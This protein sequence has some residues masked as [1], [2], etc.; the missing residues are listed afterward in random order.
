MDI[1]WQDCE[2]LVAVA[3]TGSFSAA[4]RRLNL[5]QPTVSR[6]IAALEETVERALFRRDSDGAHLT[7][8]GEKLLPAAEQMARWAEELNKT[9]SAWADIPHGVVCCATPPGIGFELIVPL[10]KIVAKKLKGVRVDL[11]TGIDHIDLTRGEAD[12]AIRTRIPTQ[13]E[14]LVLASFEVKIGVF[15]SKALHKSLPK[16]I[17]PA[18]SLPWVTWGYPMEH[19]IPR[20][21]LEAALEPFKI[22]FASNDYLAQRRAVEEGLGAFILPKIEHRFLPWKKLVEVETDLTLPPSDKFHL[23]CAKTMRHSPRVR[24][25][26]DLIIEELGGAEGV[27]LSVPE[28]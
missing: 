14:L 25:V 5:T 21:Q 26:V 4:A 13:P 2:I 8:E 16:G 7:L 19:V 22:G 18:A 6:R 11:I 1:P 10:A 24:A 27:T 20:P 17:V 23:V 28:G 3:Q 9:S 12:L 15:V